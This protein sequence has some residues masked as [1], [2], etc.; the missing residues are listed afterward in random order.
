V[1]DISLSPDAVLQ[2]EQACDR[3]EAAWKAGRRPRP[4][5]H[6]GAAGEPERSALL[7]QLLLLDWEYRRRA[8]ERPQAADY[9]T[10]FP[11]DAALVEDVGREMAESPDSTHVWPDGP[12]AGHTPWSG[13]RTA[14]GAVESVAGAEAGATRY[15]LLQEVGQ[16]GIGVVFRAR[17]RL[18][19]RELA[20][21]L[22]REDYR[23]EPEARRRF[24]EEARVGSQL[25][26]PA[27]VPVY[28]LGWFGDRRPYFTMK[29]V[30]GRTLAALLHDRADPG[31]ELPRWLGVFEQV[32]QAMAYAHARGVV[33]RDLKPANVMV[34]AFG[35]VQVMDWGFAKVLVADASPEAGAD[36]TPAV[37]TAWGRDCSSQ[38][39]ILM[40]TPAYMPPEQAK[41]EAA[42]ID[43]RAD[44]FA[45]G[46][47]LCEILTG[48]PPYLGGGA[49]E[50]FRQAAAGD[51]A[52]AHARLD[53]CRA[54][55][56]VRELAR[57]CLASDRAARPADAGAAARDLA[58]YREEAQERLRLAQLVRAAAEARAQEARAKAKAE[59]RARR[60]TLALAA[61]SVVLLAAAG[62]GWQQY[63]QASQTQA[64]RTAA[65]DGKVEAA[66]AEADALVERK[67]WSG[68]AAAATRA[69]ELLDSGAGDRWRR[70]VDEVGA[71]VDMAVRLEQARLLSADYFPLD[72][73]AASQEDVTRYAKA[74]DAYG[75]RAGMD[76]AE[77]AARVT[78]RP[79]AVR[80]AL[81]VGLQDWWLIAVKQNDAARDWLGAVL[82]AA[83]PD[84]W[85][86]QVREAVAKSDQ[87]RLRELAANADV[88]RQPEATVTLL[89][90]V[91]LDFRS[92]DAAVALL[93][94]AQRRFADDC[95]I[96]FELGRALL[97]R[98]P[99]DYPES[100]R[101]YSIAG[102]LRPGLSF[103]YY[104]NLGGLLNK[105]RDWDG[106]VA[107]SRKALELQPDS[108]QAYNHLGIALENKGDGDQAREAYG[109]AL[110]LNPD[111]A[112][113][114]YNLGLHWLHREQLGQAVAELEEAVRLAPRDAESYGALGSARYARKEFGAALAA[115]DKAI[116]LD[117]AYAIAHYDRGNV[118]LDTGRLDDAVA[119]YA[120][121]VRLDP[122]SD[123]AHCNLGNAWHRKGR[124]D[125]AVAAHSRAVELNPRSGSNHYNLGAS[126]QAA[127]DFNGAAAAYR[128]AIRL[129]PNLAE[130]HCNLAEVLREQGRFDEALAVLERGHRLGTARGPSWGYPSDQWVTQ[131]RQL[132]DLDA[133]L[134]AILNGSGKPTDAAKGIEY[135]GVCR[136]KGLYAASA[137]LYADAFT[138]E[139]ALATALN[140]GRRFQAACVAARAGAGQGRESPEP[141]AAERARWRKQA[142]DW[143]RA[144]LALWAELLDGSPDARSPAQ[145]ALRRWRSEKA[146]AG[147]REPEE[148]AKLPESERAGCIRF[149]ADV[150]DLLVR[151]L[152]S[153]PGK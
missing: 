117:P 104:V 115:F 99:P 80:E 12:N 39:G 68:A 23:D 127:A 141:D 77:A 27:I 89:A 134:P 32:C 52:D 14:A 18:L 10:R 82:Q 40:G 129:D 70:R 44:V 17:D 121:A 15:E 107:A 34:G 123:K 135:A 21:K 92:D 35:E 88:A 73:A 76:P 63:E 100:L 30:E 16:G 24:I 13:G 79:P 19:G 11:G 140:S 75:I 83:D 38:R 31:Q 152:A 91:L 128:E 33:H 94:A 126:L 143:L 58:A 136:L 37:R 56:A 122:T 25:Q 86:T 42:L 148:L 55:A 7:R 54:D 45:L 43:P 26:H 66:L 130:A 49:D 29:L 81:T 139:P 41:G 102:A 138:A 9:Q 47:I 142:L 124:L 120:Q 8:G 144:D 60:L 95:F 137:R 69:R 78:Q 74:F 133:T 71:D 145:S 5:E 20:V 98:R 118:L 119:A 72:K 1:N 4:E 84:P 93:R 147:I 50:V 125:R 65:A 113:A 109:K 106:A 103:R 151:C 132:V 97:M 2:I 53:A 36:G 57:R 146:L 46:A 87:T 90:W 64:M 28:D 62:F 116:E 101:F 111:L 112:A 110:K 61:A 149:W 59:R 48:R 105:Q 131:A 67:D 51:L 96:N 150:E 114:H 22:L 85:R 153:P 3:F 6:L 108:A